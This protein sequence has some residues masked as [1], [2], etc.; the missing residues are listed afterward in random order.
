MFIAPPRSLETVSI[1]S[2]GD[3]DCSLDLIL[4]RVLA[5]V[6]KYGSDDDA[7]PCH[8][9]PMSSSSDVTIYWTTVRLRQ[10]PFNPI[11]KIVL[12]INVQRIPI[13]MTGGKH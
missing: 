5:L 9:I 11:K 6:Q 12:L 3:K 2:L 4:C 8:L 10:Q 1:A 7:L 13:W